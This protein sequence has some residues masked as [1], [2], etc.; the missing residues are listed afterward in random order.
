MDTELLKTF[1]EVTRTRHFGRAADNLFLTQ[2][3]VSFR[4]RHLESQLDNAL[5]SRQRGN[6]QLTSAG[7]RLLPYAESILQIWGRARNDIALAEDRS[8]QLTLGASSIFWEFS[9]ISTWINSIANNVPELALRL[10]SVSRQNLSKRILDKDIDLLLT[11][12]QINNEQLICTKLQDYQLQ[13]VSHKTDRDMNNISELGL[14]YLDWSA[15]FSAQHNKIPALHR[16]PVLH[17]DSCKMAL[18]YLLDNGGV[19]YLPS[20]VVAPALANGSLHLVQDAPAVPQTLYLLSREDND[21]HSTVAAMLA[22][23]LQLD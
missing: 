15:R 6:V 7:E 8:V 23:P 17:T 2:S 11:S 3:A 16:S 20:P 1:L 22:V 9:G 5:F 19:A 14:V 12:E 18:D 10:E 4:I 21:K 13:L